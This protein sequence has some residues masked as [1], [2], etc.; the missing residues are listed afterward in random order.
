MGLQKYREA[1]RETNQIMKSHSTIDE[2]IANSPEKTRS[3][4]QII[5]KLAHQYMPTGATEAI[6]YGI[7]T[8]QVKGKNV[9][10]FA[11]FAKHVSIYPASDE[12]IDKHPVLAE[13]RTGKGTLRFNLSETVP[14][15]L[16]AIMIKFRASNTVEY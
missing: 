14:Y 2:Y 15:D 9:F 10:H 16:V 4:L 11:A 12:L 8:I 7:P 6:R 1:K 13:Y 3:I 5:R